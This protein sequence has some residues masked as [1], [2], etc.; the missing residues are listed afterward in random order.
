MNDRKL[1]QLFASA[2]KATAPTPPADFAADVLR[3]IRHEPPAA[4][5][6]ISIFD[7]LNLWF[8]RLALAASAVIV[9][10]LAADWGLAAVGVLPGADFFGCFRRLARRPL[11]GGDDCGRALRR[12]APLA[13]TNRRRSGGA[14]R[15]Q[16][17]AGRL[18]SHQRQLGTLVGRRPGQARH[19]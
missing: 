13:R 12:R 4:P 5:A 16:C 10:C 19:A 17:T 14:R 2:R 3:M 9:L 7:Q 1:K 18:G 11:A 8:P 6:T 15:H